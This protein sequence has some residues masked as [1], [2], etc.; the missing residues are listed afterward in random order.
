MMDDDNMSAL[1]SDDDTEKDSSVKTGDA[2]DE[3]EDM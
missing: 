1:P 2:A 3:T